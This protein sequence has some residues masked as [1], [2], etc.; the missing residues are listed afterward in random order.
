[1]GA[2]TTTIDGVGVFL[3][4]A[5]ADER[6]SLSEVY[7]RAWVDEGPGAVQANVSQS[8]SGVLRGLHWHREQRDYWCFLTGRAFAVL[9]DLR[10]GSPTQRAV[11]TLEVD[12]ADRRVGISVPPGVAHGFEALTDVTLLYLVDAYYTGMDEFGLAW[13]DPELAI[14]WPTRSPVL[15]ERDRSNP[16]LGEVLQDPPPLV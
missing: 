12:A 15:S 2:R 7:R 9:V 13:D 14:A 1:M 8:R 5:H 10:A 6:G 16:S 4:E 3:L 11:M